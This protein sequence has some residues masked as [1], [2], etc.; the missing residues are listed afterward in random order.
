[1]LGYL[2]SY[3]VRFFVMEN[4]HVDARVLSGIQPIFLFV[5]KIIYYDFHVGIS[6]L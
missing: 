1:M 2:G 3:Q 5:V 6:S 4:L